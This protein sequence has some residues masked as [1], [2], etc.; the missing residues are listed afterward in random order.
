MLRSYNPNARIM[1]KADASKNSSGAVLYQEEEDDELHP[2][3]FFSVKHTPAEFNYDI[4]D[5]ELLAIVK[6]LKEWRPEL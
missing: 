4:G 6:A 5:Q 2:I 1:V 3:A